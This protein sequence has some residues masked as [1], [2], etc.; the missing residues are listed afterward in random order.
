[1]ADLRIP[2]AAADGGI[3]TVSVGVT[4]AVPTVGGVPGQLIKTADE[5]LAEAKRAGRDRVAGCRPADV[6][7]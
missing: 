3:V 4:S 6:F 5:V 2:H 1:M 7:R